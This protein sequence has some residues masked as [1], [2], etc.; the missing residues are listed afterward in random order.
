MFTIIKVNLPQKDWYLSFS[1]LS[2]F[3]FLA[4]TNLI[5]NGSIFDLCNF[6]YKSPHHLNNSVVP[7]TIKCLCIFSLTIKVFIEARKLSMHEK[8][9]WIA[10]WV[11][12]TYMPLIHFLLYV[13]FSL[14]ID[15][16]LKHF[17]VVAGNTVFS[18]YCANH[19]RPLQIQIP[20]IKRLDTNV[21]LHLY[22]L[23]IL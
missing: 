16:Q 19:Y 12:I 18:K 6:T 5:R 20:R 15:I 8:L 14:D 4:R 17:F 13:C 10:I 7:N 21:A 9:S 22:H 1:F 23:A 2:E 11:F 3:F